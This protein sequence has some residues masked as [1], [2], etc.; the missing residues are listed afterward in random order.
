MP[1]QVLPSHSST[2]IQAGLICFF[3]PFP[4]K[5]APSLIEVPTATEPG[6]SPLG[7]GSASEESCHLGL[8]LW[9]LPTALLLV[10]GLEP[11]TQCKGANR[12]GWRMP[13]GIAAFRPFFFF[14]KIEHRALFFFYNVSSAIHLMTMNT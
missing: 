12:I 5:C 3:F 8:W 13:D 11:W 14:R 9:P 7:T 1:I 6:T 10:S 4:H 2:Y